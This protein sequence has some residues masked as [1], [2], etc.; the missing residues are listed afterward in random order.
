MTVPAARFV[1]KSL[2][3][4]VAP[5]KSGLVLN[6]DLAQ[7]RRNSLHPPEGYQI[8]LGHEPDRLDA[9]RP[10]TQAAIW[11]A[12]DVV[13]TGGTCYTAVP[14][15]RGPAFTTISKYPPHALAYRS[16]VSIV[17]TGPLNASILA[18]AG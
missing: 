14:S 16:I 4:A 2:L 7:E 9:A 13:V 17:G 12:S 8:E 15:D 3:R 6:N 5:A 18:I 1:T 11:A 10:A